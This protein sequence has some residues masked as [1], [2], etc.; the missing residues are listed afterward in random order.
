MQIDFY[1]LMDINKQQGL[2]W[3]CE[4]VEK[5]YLEQASIFIQTATLQAAEYLDQLLWTYRDHT[6][7]PHHLAH[8]EEKKPSSYEKAA[9]CFSPIHIGLSTP[10]LFQ[11]IV[12]N[13]NSHLTLETTR[14]Q[15]LI[16]IVFPDKDVQQLARERYKQY[17][18]QNHAI[19]TYKINASDLT[20]DKY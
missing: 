18:Q 20:H 10:P 6:F 13:L 2:Q 7:I 12:F 14:Y 1:V 5:Y 8:H 3:V 15:R 19:T 16:E 11:G 17:Q 9:N 4:W